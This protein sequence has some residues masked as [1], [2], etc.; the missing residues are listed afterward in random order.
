LNFELTRAA[1]AA[2]VLSLAA[3]SAA[4]DLPAP[5]GRINDFASVLDEATEQELDALLDAVERETTAQVAVATVP[6]LQGLSVEEFALKL[7]KAW[8]VGQKGKDN[9]VL[10]LV[11]PNDRAI[12]IEVGYGL[13]GVLPDGLAGQIIR[14]EF[15]PPFR[16]GNYRLGILAGVRRIAEVVRKNE[17]LTP[18]QIQ[19]LAQP[20]GPPVVE[21]PAWVLVAFL[22]IF[23]AIGTHIVGLGLGAKVMSFL[24]GGG[25]LAAVG[26]Y[27]SYLA[28]AAAALGLVPVG[29]LMLWWGL[30]RTQDAS[31]VSTLRGPN[32][33]SG[34][35]LLKSRAPRGRSER[36]GSS[37]GGRSGGSSGGGGGSFG[38]GRSGG[39]GAS[40]R[41]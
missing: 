40:G 26:S 25:L 27:V 32:T 24:I 4:Q 41:W 14:N 8:G 39:G 35:W 16:D 2:L 13:E 11:A 3:T 37:S 38:G 23:V 7:F 33:R 19:A 18:E 9:G 22:G 36:Y 34:G 17:R 10:V 15:T 31:Y 29:A 21:L 28:G 5:T 1:L 12:R 30:R 6:S 20:A